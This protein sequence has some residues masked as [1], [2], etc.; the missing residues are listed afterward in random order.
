VVEYLHLEEPGYVLCVIE[1][2]SSRLE[3]IAA[4]ILVSDTQNTNDFLV[5]SP[6]APGNPAFMG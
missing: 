5:Q 1:L 4:N 2:E 6:Q 3:Q